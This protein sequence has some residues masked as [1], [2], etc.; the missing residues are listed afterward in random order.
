MSETTDA[1]D[2]ILRRLLSEGYDVDYVEDTPV[3]VWVIV[4]LDVE[5]VEA[6]TA[7]IAQS[8]LGALEGNARFGVSRPTI[9]HE[10][11]I[12]EFY[13]MPLPRVLI[14][15]EYPRSRFGFS[16]GEADAV[17]FPLQ[18]EE[19]GKWAPGIAL[20]TEHRD[21]KIHQAYLI[22]ASFEALL[23]MG[24]EQTLRTL[25]EQCSNAP[26]MVALRLEQN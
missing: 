15:V 25:R 11:R 21:N 18:M 22:E 4:P 24:V 14:Q 6:Y 17:V 10:K 3:K 13:V 20:P 2:A 12:F 1:L 7:T 9:L 8:A 23:G 5:D 16:L 26:E 19:R